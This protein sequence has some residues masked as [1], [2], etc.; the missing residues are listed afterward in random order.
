M[1]RIF[2]F[3]I[4]A[5]VAAAGFSGT[6]MATPGQGT[7]PIFGCH[8]IITTKTDV[9]TVTVESD[10]FV[11]NGARVISR[12]YDFGDNTG[13]TTNA[14]GSAPVTHTYEGVGLYRIT[15]TFQF[16]VNG[17]IRIVSDSGCQA[18]FT[19]AAPSTRTITVMA[20]MLACQATPDT[21]C[22]ETITVP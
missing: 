2:I 7:S 20:Q 12:T 21:N 1:N 13:V 19:V 8:R 4:A 10:A 17:R 14:P 11:A 16:N 9:S 5:M 22:R 6:A 3:V 15:V 18:T